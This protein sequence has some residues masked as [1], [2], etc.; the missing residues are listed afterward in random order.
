MK[1]PEY[2][3]IV[4]LI[5]VL[6][7]ASPAFAAVAGHVQF[8]SGVVNVINDRGVSHIIRKGDT[9]YAGD[10][11]QTGATGSAQLRMVDDGFISVRPRSKLRIDEYRY[12]KTKDDSS[13]FS[14]LQGNFR[15]LTGLI[16]KYN[17]KAWQTRTKT[18]VLG[19]R[20]SDADIGF[21][22]GN[23]LTA[24]RTFTGG[25]TLTP[26]DKTLPSLNVDAGGI[27]VFT[28]GSPPRMASRFPFGPPAP[29]PQP[30][31]QSG[32]DDGDASG[33]EVDED[34]PLPPPPTE[35]EGVASQPTSSGDGTTSTTQ[36]ASTLLPPLPA[37]LPIS[38]GGTVLSSQTT[39]SG[40]VPAPT[41]SGGVGAYI[42]LDPFSRQPSPNSGS[43]VFNGTAT[44]SGTISA[45]GE[46]LTLKTTTL[47][48]AFA[49]DAGTA[50]HIA[51][52]VFTIPALSGNTS[53][54]GN[55]GV[56]SGNYSVV[57]FGASQTPIGNFYYAWGEKI[58]T[59]AQ[60]ASLANTRFTFSMLSGAA[61][62]ETGAVANGFTVGAVGTFSAAQT[63]G[64]I[65]VTGNASFAAGS[66]GWSFTGTGNIADLINQN[67]G[68]SMSATCR[69]CSTASG[70]AN[71]QFVGA[72]AEGLVMS[73][74]ASDFVGKGMV[75]AAI[76]KR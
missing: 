7:I 35:V 2:A 55:W 22:P 39:T 26:K 72:Q 42:A 9:I 19:V 48:G 25:Y 61:G 45:A 41:G 74:H 52:A 30:N 34:A 70:M 31:R 16:A 8:V 44:R 58:T 76:L 49:F 4:I 43:I 12:N 1:Q 3:R 60:L 68:L 10:M 75:G 40:P 46:L 65:T 69:G 53:Y 33:G 14:L 28:P 54:R 18:A 66:S 20:G 36:T 37:Q 73:I 59:A 51:G 50:T 29:S 38:S 23:N 27:G 47:D 6:L 13:F 63:L 17:R 5:A 57:D 15:A 62:N 21:N 32:G 56:W 71:G 11:I 64:T 67:T 24:V